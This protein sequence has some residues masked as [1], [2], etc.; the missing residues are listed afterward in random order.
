MSK[1]SSDKPVNNSAQSGDPTESLGPDR[2]K[3]TQ[4][5]HN[6]EMAESGSSIRIVILKH[7]VN[8]GIREEQKITAGSGGEN[9]DVDRLQGARPNVHIIMDVEANTKASAKQ[10]AAMEVSTAT[11]N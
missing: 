5:K 9:M 2:C 8:E 10:L 11:M 3:S 1:K 7:K 6:E 4:L